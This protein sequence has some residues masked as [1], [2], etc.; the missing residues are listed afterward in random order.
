[1]IWSEWYLTNK[2]NGKFYV[3]VYVLDLLDRQLVSTR[4]TESMHVSTKQESMKRWIL[5]RST[6]HKSLQMWILS[7]K[8]TQTH[9]CTVHRDTCQCLQIHRNFDQVGSTQLCGRIT[10]SVILCLLIVE[11]MMMSMITRRMLDFTT[12]KQGDPWQWAQHKCV[13]MCIFKWKLM[14]GMYTFLPYSSQQKPNIHLWRYIFVWPQT[15]GISVHHTCVLFMNLIVDP[16]S[17][18]AKLELKR[19]Q[20]G[21]SRQRMNK[22]FYSIFSWLLFDSSTCKCECTHTQVY[23]RT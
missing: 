2:T 9:T 11:G 18:P 16:T 12:D 4:W 5:T 7:R 6:F 19:D 1:M 14:N 3:N 17:K 8:S 13:L 23:W 21:Y 15:K 10:V 22:T 20:Y